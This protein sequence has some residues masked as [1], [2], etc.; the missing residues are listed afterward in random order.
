M[1]YDRRANDPLVRDLHHK[2]LKRLFETPLGS[3]LDLENT[4]K[5]AEKLKSTLSNDPKLQALYHVLIDKLDQFRKA[6][7]GLRK[8]INDMEDFE[9]PRG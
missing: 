8:A 9:F 5:M 1:T 4:A 3:D 6:R 7:G 2:L